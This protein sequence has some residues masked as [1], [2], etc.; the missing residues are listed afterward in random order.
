[1]KILEKKGFVLKWITG[2]HYIFARP[3]IKM[4]VVVPYHSKGIPKGTLLQILDD[5][6]ISWDG[7]KELP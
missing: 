7:L 3:E 5:A 1:M 4:R 6:G 2:T